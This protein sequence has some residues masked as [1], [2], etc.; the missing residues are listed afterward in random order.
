MAN[1]MSIRVFAT[2]VLGR[3]AE[4]RGARMLWPGRL[5]WVVDANNR[6]RLIIE[7]CVNSLASNLVAKHRQLIRESQLGQR[8]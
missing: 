1:P 5:K 4:F 8:M 2:L 6:Y 3:R 7:R